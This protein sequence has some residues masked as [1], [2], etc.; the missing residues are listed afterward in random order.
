[1][2]SEHATL[3]RV[4]M[5]V[6]PALLCVAGLAVMA[7]KASA[8]TNA[9]S[10]PAP[11]AMP[12]A[13]TNTQ[14]T[15]QTAEPGTHI[16]E[17]IPRAALVGRGRFTW[18]GFHVYDGALFAPE[19]KFDVNQPHA[20]ELTYARE[21]KGVKI[22]E[23]SIDEIAALGI[24]TETERAAWLPLL[25]RIFPDV[26]QGDRLAGV[27]SS[28]KAQFFFNGKAAGEITDAKLARAFFAIWLDARTSAPAFRAR[29]LGLDK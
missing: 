14:T 6:F 2:R 12:N 18:F 11:G 20:L 9:Q 21:L 13:P 22:A 23:R 16:R 15:A 7:T 26:R 1:M 28:D 19:R 4:A 5:R 29:L 27:S 10:D 25:T 3:T 24:G 8:Q 17:L